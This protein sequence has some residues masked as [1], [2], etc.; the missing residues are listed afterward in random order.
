MENRKSYWDSIYRTNLEKP[1]TDNWLNCYIH[2]FKNND[3]ILE[4]GCG[5]GHL[6]EYLL[7]NGYNILSTDI[8]ET[9]LKNYLSRVPQASVKQIDL[10]KK[11]PFSDN[12]FNI[13]IA[14][15]CL[16]YFS[17]SN[18]EKI[19]AEIRRILTCG[20][21]LFARVNSDKDKNFGAGKGIIQ[22]KGFYNFHGHYKRFFTREMIETFLM[23]GMSFQLQKN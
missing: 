16:H 6:S 2:L 1:D 17:R 12:S 8:S 22:E 23:N 4:L 20:G 21:Y 5:E 9:A 3:K 19:I 18:T 14:D 10:L 13:I 11:L 7:K 15:L